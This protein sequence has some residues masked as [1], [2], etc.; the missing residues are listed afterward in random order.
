M[1][2]VSAWYHIVLAFDTTDGT[3]ANRLKVY[4]NGS[5]VTSF[6]TYD[7]S[8]QN[9][10][11]AVNSTSNQYISKRNYVDDRYYDGY[12][13]EFYNIDGQQ[14]GKQRTVFGYQRMRLV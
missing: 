11:T 12:L 5:Q 14:L 6:S 7:M 13:A 2:D 8:S 1:R 3:A 4:I 9:F 10:N